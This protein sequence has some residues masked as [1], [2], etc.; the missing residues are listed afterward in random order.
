[1]VVLGFPPFYRTQTGGQPLDFMVL[2]GANMACDCAMSGAAMH[3]SMPL[4]G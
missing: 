1:M 2:R 3:P 4:E